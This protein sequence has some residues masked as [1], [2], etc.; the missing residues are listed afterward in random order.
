M[1][2]DIG[3]FILEHRTARNLSSRKLALMANISH[4]EIHRLEN[5]ERKNPSPLVLKYIANALDLPYED[6]MR[7]AGYMDIASP[8][9]A[10]S[11]RLSGIDDLTDQ[12]IEEVNNFIEFL[13]NKRNKQ[14]SKF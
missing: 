4:T 6:I 3:K 5:G 14:Q 13:H 11:T 10:T 7:A 12:E 1:L 8:S 9:S 2:S